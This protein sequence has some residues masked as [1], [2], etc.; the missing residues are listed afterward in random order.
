VGTRR[1]R[2]IVTILIVLDAVLAGAAT[3]LVTRDTDSATRPTEVV[4]V[5]QPQV[6]GGA[7]EQPVEASVAP[8][9]A[10]LAPETTGS[11]IPTTSTPT[12][13]ISRPATTPPTAAELETTTTT[14]TIGT[15]PSTTT[16]TTGEPQSGVH[17]GPAEAPIAQDGA[18]P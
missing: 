17:T 1:A 2:S 12:T 13:S 15:A 5:T 9:G 11:S 6:P 10:Q 16:T 14:P 18:T 7:L 3:A 8:E 4:A